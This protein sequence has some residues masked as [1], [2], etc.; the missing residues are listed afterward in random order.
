MHLAGEEEEENGAGPFV[1]I[2]DAV[3]NEQLSVDST[4][5]EKTSRDF[6]QF[7]RMCIMSAGKHAL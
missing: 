4:L 1:D 2:D 3:P 7:V 5:G 6:E